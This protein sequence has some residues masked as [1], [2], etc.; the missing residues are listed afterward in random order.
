MPSAA[1]SAARAILSAQA[2][3]PRSASSTA[4]ARSG[5][6]AMLVRPTRTS[7]IRPSETLTTALTATMAQSS[8]RRLNFS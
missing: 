7:S 3:W 8:E 6:E 4:V 1:C 2:S 5:V